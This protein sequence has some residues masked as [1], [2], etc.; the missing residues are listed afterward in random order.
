MTDFKFRCFDI[1]RSKSC[2]RALAALLVWL[3][4]ISSPALAQIAWQTEWTQRLDAA[5]KEGK[6]VFSIP[7][8]TELRTR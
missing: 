8:S 1:D 3:I 5:K 4:F 6:V 7:P 2:R